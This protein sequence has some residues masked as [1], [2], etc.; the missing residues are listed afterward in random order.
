MVQPVDRRSRSRIAAACR[1][2][3]CLVT[4]CLVATCLAAGIF[5][6]APA[7][8]ADGARSATGMRTASVRLASAQPVRAIRQ[9]IFAM[10]RPH[11]VSNCR[12]PRCGND[13]VLFLGIGY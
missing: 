4:A 13:V 3:A 2:A 11:R 8:A 7:A 10:P 1:I 6:S 12:A 5:I 9:W